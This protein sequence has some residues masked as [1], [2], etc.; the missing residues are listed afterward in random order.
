MHLAKFSIYYHGKRKNI[1]V[2]WP[3]K[4]QTFTAARKPTFVPT[5]AIMSQSTRGMTLSGKQASE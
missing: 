4:S 1:Q 5:P 3:A 2:L